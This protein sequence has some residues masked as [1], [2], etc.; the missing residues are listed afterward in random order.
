M[1]G[2]LGGMSEDEHHLLTCL[3]TYPLNIDE[4]VRISGYDSAVLADLLIRLELRGVVRQLPGQ[5]YE[6]CQ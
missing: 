6:L 4:L 1:D 3:D 2:Q 5:Q